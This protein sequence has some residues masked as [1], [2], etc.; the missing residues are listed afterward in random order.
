MHDGQYTMHDKRPTDLSVLIRE[1]DSRIW[2]TRRA[3]ASTLALYDARSDTT[4][5][6]RLL[7]QFICQRPRVVD[8]CAVPR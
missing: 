4:H 2:T 1:A 3:Y 7:L 8:L 5:D 6:S